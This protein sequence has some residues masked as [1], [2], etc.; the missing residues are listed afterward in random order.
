MYLEGLG[1]SNDTS[2]LNPA[3][4]PSWSQ[5]VTNFDAAAAN[6]QRVLSNLQANGSYVSSRHPELQSQYNSLLAEGQYNANLMGELRETRNTIQNWLGYLQQQGQSITSNAESAFNSAEAAVEEGWNWL[7]GEAGLSGLGQWQIGLGVVAGLAIIASIVWWITDAQ[8]FNARIA[9]IKQNEAQG[10][11][12]AQ[13]VQNT[14]AALGP[15]PGSTP[16]WAGAASQAAS[17]PW[18]WIMGALVA[19]VL[20]PPVIREVNG[21]R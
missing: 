13:A 1:V 3:D 11:T 6:F 20:L 14:N 18:G 5:F 17:L 12:P 7:A 15:P 19:V 16:T 9:M 10:Q 21:G 4:A 2:S 8:Q